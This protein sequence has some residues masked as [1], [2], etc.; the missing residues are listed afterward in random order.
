MHRF[1]NLR[2]GVIRLATDA[3]VYHGTP[4]EI[5]DSPARVLLTQ[6]HVKQYMDSGSIVCQTPDGKLH[7]KGARKM[8]QTKKPAKVEQSE[9]SAAES[10]G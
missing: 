10:D 3:P 4:T 1:F 9:D 8:K 7:G 2:G 5:E 6:P